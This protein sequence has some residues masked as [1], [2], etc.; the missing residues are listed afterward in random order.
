MY[1]LVW[2]ENG[3]FCNEWFYSYE[4]ALYYWIKLYDRGI[5]GTIVKPEDQQKE[6]EY[7]YLYRNA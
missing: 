1:N 3:D 7:G 4:K 2:R 6:R 5:E